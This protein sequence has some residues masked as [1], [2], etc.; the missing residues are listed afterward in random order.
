MFS[1]ISDV[2]AAATKGIAITSVNANGSLFF[3]TDNGANWQS[4]GVVSNSSAVLLDASS[5]VFFKPN[6]NWNGTVDNAFLYLA[7]DQTNSPAATVGTK[8]N[9][10]A[11]GTSTPYSLEV[12]KV[13]ISVTAVNDAPSVSGGPVS[14]LEEDKGAIL[15]TALKFNY[16]DVD[17]H[18]QAGVIFTEL[19]DAAKATLLLNGVAI[20]ANTLV[21]IA[22][23]DALKVELKPVANFNGAVDLKFKAV[24]TSATH[25]ESAVVTSTFNFNNV[26]DTPVG[27]NDT[28]T[29]DEAGGTANAITGAALTSTTSGVSALN[30]LTNDT[31]ADS[32]DTKVVQ[33][34]KAGTAAGAGTAVIAA[35]TSA[36][37]T[38]VVGS[39]G[40]IKI[41]ADGSYSYVVDQANATVK[42]LAVGSTAINDVFTYTVKDTAGATSTATVTVSITGANDAPVI[43]GGTVNGL[44]ED[45]GAILKSSLK[46]N[47]A[48][49]DGHAQKGVIYTELPDASKAT[50]LLNGTPIT[51]GTLIT[52]EDINADKVLLMPVANFNGAVSL[53]FK[54]VDTSATN[55]ES[56]EVTSTYNFNSANDAPVIGAGTLNLPTVDEDVAAP[57]NGDTSAG[58]AV[59]DMFS[60]ISDVDAAATKGIAIT[61]VNAN[62]SLFFSTDNG[63]NW[64]S[65]GVV[66]N[67]SAVLLDASSRVFFKP[68]ANWN[69]TVD[70]AFLY[71]AWDQTNSPAATVGTKVNVAATGT[72]TPYSLEVGKVG[73]SVTA[74]NDAPSV[75][76]GPVSGLEE[77]KGAIL[78]TALKFNYAD[79]DGHTQAGVIFTEL[80]DAAKATL[81][82]NGVAITANTLVTIA[83]IDAL[84]VELKPVANFNGAVDLKF[85]AVDTSATSNESAVVTSTFN[86]GNVNDAPVLADTTLALSA[87]AQD[88]PVPTGAVGSLVSSLVGGV[89]DVDAS[90]LKG[91]AITGVGNGTLYFST[92]GGSTWT[93]V[94]G[95]SNTNALLLGSDTDN[96]LYFKPA[97]GYFGTL[98]DAVT[99]RAWDQTSGTEGS[100]VSTATNGGATAF[101]NTTDTISQ[102][103]VRPVTVNTV[104]SDSQ[105]VMNEAVPLT[106]TADPNATVN[107]N[108]NGTMRTVVADGS[109]NWSYSSKL[110]PL[111]RYVMVRDVL[112]GTSG[113]SSTGFLSLSELRVMVDGV[114]VAAGRAVTHGTG[115]VLAGATLPTTSLLTDGSTGTH[116]EYGGGANAE[117]W[118]EV[119]LGDYYR[120]DT[121]EVIHR[122]TWPDRLNG[123]KIY[124]ALTQQSLATS[125][126]LLTASNA[127]P[128]T[129]KISTISGLVTNNATPFVA[130]QANA[131]D[132]DP[133]V[134]GTN[135][136]TATQ[137][138][139]GLSSSDTENVVWKATAG[140]TDITAPVF[141]SGSAVSVAENTSTATTIYNAQATDAGGA[142]DVGITYS[143]GGVDAARFNINASTGVVTFRV[144]PDFEAPVDSGGNNVYNIIVFA[145]DASFNR[146]S[147]AVTVTVTDVAAAPVVLD[148]NRDGTFSYGEVVMD[149]NSDG[150]VDVTM[151]AA[152]Q[153][154]ILVWDKYGDGMVYD[155]TQ[156][157][158]TLY[159][160]ATDLAGLAAGFDS[161]RDNKFN[162]LDAQF[163]EFM[164]WQ[165]QD[166][167]GVSDAGEV[168]SLSDWGIS[169][170][171][172]LS[173]GVQRTPAEGVIE[174]GRSTASTRDGQT[175]L[176]A[177]AAFEYRSATPEELA[178]HALTQAYTMKEDRFLDLGAFLSE[179]GKDQID[180]GLGAADLRRDAGVNEVRMNLSDVLS[181]DSQEGLYQQTLTGDANDQMLCTEG[182]WT[183]REPVLNL[184]EQSYV[185]YSDGSNA[186]DQLLIDQQMSSQ[187]PFL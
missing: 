145:R 183:T 130:T 41:G 87:V 80:P 50:L 128:P 69:G 32:G 165:D 47:Y 168:R 124:T 57:A 89:S 72:S 18:T 144:A 166:Q 142:A 9:V 184:V 146:S 141:S 71:L 64:Q 13:G 16:A 75:S 65:A 160:G 3:S 56:A 54:A 11:T 82:L 74:V 23:I 131:T 162:A 53:K 86:F 111:I 92:N 31:D 118:V 140:T 39:F 60:V 93:A 134:N 51:S 171:D 115:K 155:H 158:F 59:S 36:N 58:I 178:E 10:A 121:V 101:S 149:V 7:W 44:T 143:L 24:D 91:V 163:S 133:F 105:I 34:I 26:N 185:V 38:E 107:L 150:V 179:L 49:D 119:D 148:L 127:N 40:T 98:N 6:A 25:N 147:Q 5:R 8:V 48:D 169:E 67:S 85:K 161:H 170:I 42:A 68:N 43:S 96:R 81:L 21:T 173:D 100:Y 164:V 117:V 15:T 33:D 138:A 4:A 63:A 156:Y 99:I 78:T 45:M 95:A 175:L 83:D 29:I 129:V 167:D 94:T 151:W 12:G 35:T 61:S 116:T 46:F 77:D 176:V 122:L 177:D 139:G 19:P 76:G 157:S 123:A 90:A 186:S 52:I 159:G 180:T 125:A 126:E 97:S 106:G 182:T 152:A 120:V 27:V 104:S 172:L 22:D 135:V 28:A 132:D 1:V 113:S 108:I 112:D 103:V 70:N 187:Y 88:A 79:V 20:T 109:G 154:G 137:T 73:I 153:D 62:G 17:G 114:D 14:G 102:Q 136:I 55:N 174:A 2:D 181:L 66:S 84:K 110:V 30:V 37:G